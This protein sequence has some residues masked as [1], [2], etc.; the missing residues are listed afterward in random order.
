MPIHVCNDRIVLIK[1]LTR[2]Q[3]AY[4]MEGISIDSNELEGQEIFVCHL[5][6]SPV[7]AEIHFKKIE[8]ERNI[9]D[10]ISTM[11]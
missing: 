7:T 2:L 5:L 10:E 6:L 11:I 9:T 3:R 8:S 1:K 4:F